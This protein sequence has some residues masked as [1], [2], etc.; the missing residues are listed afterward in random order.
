MS[1][2]KRDGIYGWKE[3]NSNNT[4]THTHKPKSTHTNTH[5]HTYDMSVLYASSECG[6]TSVWACEQARTLCARALQNWIGHKTLLQIKLVSLYWLKMADL[7]WLNELRC[8]RAFVFSSSLSL[9]IHTFI[10]DL[11]TGFVKTC[12]WFYR[13]QIQID[14]DTVI[15]LQLF[16]SLFKKI[17]NRCRDFIFWF[18]LFFFSASF[19]QICYNFYGCLLLLF[20]GFGCFFFNLFCSV[21]V[22]SKSFKMQIHSKKKF[23]DLPRW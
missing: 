14:Y 12:V 18:L 3:N 19:W 6:I 5:G 9:F 13:I 23:N 8:F 22:V 20:Y 7:K 17:R 10:I 1:V 16:A 2:K 15:R 4:H 11:V 21:S